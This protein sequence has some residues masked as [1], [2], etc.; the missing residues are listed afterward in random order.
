[1]NSVRNPLVFLATLSLLAGA[2]LA[3]ESPPAS[4]STPEVHQARAL[5]KIGR[6]DIVRDEMRFSEQ[7]AADFWPVY[8][9]YQ[10]DLQSVRDRFADLLVNYSNAYRAGTVTEELANQF[11]DEYLDIQQQVLSVKQDYLDDF[12]AVLPARKAGRFYQLE[13][14]MEV[15]LEYELSRIVPLMDPV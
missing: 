8:D 4:A 10:A 6:E 12:R 14:K 11:V 15:E 3:E 7:E 5:L 1:M 2:S 13:N 9:S